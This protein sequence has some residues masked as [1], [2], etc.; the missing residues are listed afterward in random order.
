MKRNYQELDKL[1]L[2]LIWMV[3]GERTNWLRIENQ[4]E[5]VE[6]G[7]RSICNY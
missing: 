5:I 3:L 7:R 2:N 1:D 4:L 6:R